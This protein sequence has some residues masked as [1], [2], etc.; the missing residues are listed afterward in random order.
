M[1]LLIPKDEAIRILKDRLQELNLNGFNPKVWK[2]RTILDLKQIF[3]LLG[4][5]WLQISSLYFDTAIT[6]QKAQKL[7]ESKQ[8][9]SGLL[10]SYI[11]FIEQY[12]KIASQRNQIKEQG[13][14]AKYY[15]LFAEYNKNGSE[16]ISLMNEYSTLLNANANLLVQLSESQDENTR[17]IDNTLQLGNVT[18]K[19]LWL[20]VQNLKTIQFV[21][22]FSVLA[23]LLIAAFTIGQLIERNG[24]NNESFDLKTENRE[25]K[26]NTQKFQSQID[27]QKTTIKLHEE[28]I[29]KL[30]ARFEIKK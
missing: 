6:S 26:T 29:K 4:D 24:A 23:A 14:E 5:Q 25:L 16:Y 9:A 1:Q 28:E 15:A 27:I 10:H 7:I 8:A 20:G 19:R 3:G 21:T 30:N 13:F 17:L 12:S 11:D 22:I 2:D 18:I